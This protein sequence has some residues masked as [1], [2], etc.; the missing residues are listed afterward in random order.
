MDKKIMLSFEEGRYGVSINE[1]IIYET[2]DMDDA[3]SKYK[4]LIEDNVVIQ[5]NSWERILESLNEYELEIN[6]EYKT[7]SYDS[8]KFFYNTGKC[9]AILNGQMILLMG[10]VNTFT[11]IIDISENKLV[12]LNPLVSFLNEISIKGASFRFVDKSIIV[13]SPMFNYGN[14]QFDFF[15]NKINQGATIKKESWGYFENYILHILK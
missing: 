6:K 13:S 2:K 12:D 5:S 14:C 8:L 9:F 15:T 7:L 10:G 4:K 3:I 1:N 11:A